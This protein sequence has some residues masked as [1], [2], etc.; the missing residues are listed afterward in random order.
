MTSLL[1]CG[2]RL[3]ARNQRGARTAKPHRFCKPAVEVLEDRSLLSQTV[4]FS[5]S[6]PGV[7][8]TIPYWGLDTNWPSSDNLKR[9]LIFMGSENVNVVRMP[10]TVDAPLLNGD[11]T[12][13][14]K[15]RLQQS[16]DLA[17]MAGSDPMWYMSAGA[18]V[19]PM[20]LERRQPRVSGSLGSGDGG[21]P[22]ILQQ[23]H[24][25]G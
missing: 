19:G 8:A 25:D 10:A 5:T 17:A 4:T 15:A 2:K 20:V 7:S 21:I 24:V 18:P 3:F 22:A 16:I 13:A 23:A 14:D 6:D 12:D 11:I 9:G 1:A